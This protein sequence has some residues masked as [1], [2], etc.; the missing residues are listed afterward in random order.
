[1]HRPDATSEPEAAGQS[2]DALLGLP[3]AKPPEAR[4]EPASG[5]ETAP[6]APADSPPPPE[7]IADLANEP[8]AGDHYSPESL[9]DRASPA[10]AA[11]PE[12]ELALR[13]EL[14]VPAPVVAS[15]D[16]PTALEPTADHPDAVLHDEEQSTGADPLL[17][18]PEARVPRVR[19]DRYRAR[20]R[21]GAG[22][23]RVCDRPRVRGCASRRILRAPQSPGLAGETSRGNRDLRFR[24]VLAAPLRGPRRDALPRRGAP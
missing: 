7:F 17:L 9:A 13:E 11:E 23:A 8:D 12:L 24:T 18:E 19:G 14:A 5:E 6:E 4:L 20:H 22:G 1:M 16:D 3:V 21:R 15:L 10:D 2:P